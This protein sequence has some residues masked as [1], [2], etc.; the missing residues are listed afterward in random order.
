MHISVQG[1]NGLFIYFFSFHI[2]Y[3]NEKT[4]MQT[5]D[6]T[7]FQVVWDLRAVNCTSWTLSWTHA[8]TRNLRGVVSSTIYQ[9]DLP[10][11]GNNLRPVHY[12]LLVKTVGFYSSPSVRPS[13]RLPVQLSVIV[14]LVG[15]ARRAADTTP[16]ACL[17]R[18][19]CGA[20][21]VDHTPRSS[22]PPLT[23]DTNI[24]PTVVIIQGEIL[25]LII[26][27]SLTAD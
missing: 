22:S 12:S 2:C 9:D 13:L 21:R 1:G 7:L 17:P 14:S 15:E 24:I 10:A 27:T 20:L 26:S 4:E 19:G 16:G 18:C 25:L 23:T 5:L 3:V 6:S 8:R 11:L